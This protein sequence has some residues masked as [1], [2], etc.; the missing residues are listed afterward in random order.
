MLREQDAF[1]LLESR[2]ALLLM[3]HSI[4][5]PKLRLKVLFTKSRPHKRKD[6]TLDRK[7]K[8]KQPL[9]DWINYVRAAYSYRPAFRDPFCDCDC[10]AHLSP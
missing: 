10:M 6:K 3:A 5:Q 4:S 1:A 9:T 2:M 7:A 8:H